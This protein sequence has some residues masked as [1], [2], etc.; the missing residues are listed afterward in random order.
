MMKVAIVGGGPAGLYLALLVKRRR[1]EIDIEVFEQNPRCAT[2]GFGIVLADRGLDRMQRADPESFEMIKSAM[3]IT[4]HQMIYHREEPIFVERVGFGGALARIRLLTILQSC[5]E[6]LGIK[7]NYESRTANAEIDADIVVGADG[8]NS[9]VRRDLEKEFGTTSF[10]LTNR[11]AWYGV[12]KHFPYPMLIFR[13]TERGNFIA[14]AYP[15][16]DRMSTFVAECDNAT[17]TRSS[18][19]QMS[20]D[21]RRLVAEEVF[22]PELGGATLLS[23]KS[24]WRQLPV[25]RN[26]RWFSG[27]RVLLGDALHSAHPSIGSGTRIAMEDSIALAESI[28]AGQSSVEAMLSSFQARRQGEKQKLLDA[29]RRS[30]SW[31]ET[32]AEKMERLEPVDFVFD[33]MMRT[34]RIT[35]DRLR[36]E[37]PNFMERYGPLRSAVRDDAQIE[38]SAA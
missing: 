33:Y 35:E 27:N 36:A 10:L 7:V 21:E 3:Y 32:F 34:G 25:V 22:A 2:Y 30:F 6:R 23:N 12:D 28:T 31:Y 9:V 18:M 4:R 14:V 13:S 20:E 5:C 11:M 24:V 19:D 37:F 17:W 8:I 26:S 16:S 15:Y 29:T 1:P 38:P